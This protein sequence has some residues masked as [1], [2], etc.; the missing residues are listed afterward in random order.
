[1]QTPH[2]RAREFVL[3]LSCRDTKGIV[4]AVSGLLFQAGCNIID[5]QQYGDLVGPGATGRFFMRVHFE[6]PPQLADVAT[7]DRMLSNVREQFAMEAQLHALSRRPRVMLMVSQHGHCLNDLLFRWHSGQLDVDIPA[8]VSNHT[9]FADLAASYGLP[10][11]HLP[12]AAGAAPEAR[13]AQEQAIEAIVE[14][15][16]VDL[17]V[18][19]RYMQIL[20]PAL[21]ATLEG[22][23]INIHHSFLP[24]FKGAKPYYQAHDRG[25]KLI[26]ATAHYVTED[27]DEGPI[28]EQD[29]ERVDHSATPEDLTAIGRDVECVVLARAVRWHVEHRVL[30]NG[31]KTVV[32]K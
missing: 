26:G 1:M 2:S 30:R 8:I 13:R 29:V 22:R 16:D 4:H 28:I 14:R 15:E 7:L 27:L 25:V 20:S 5:S 9:A 18:L 24:S 3:K 6:A 11:H 12:V 21:C 17:V 31:R 10:F 32:F 23:A 19:A